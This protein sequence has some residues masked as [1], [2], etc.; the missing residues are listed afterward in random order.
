MRKLSDYILLYLKGLAM[1]ATDM[2]GISGGSVAL[3]TGL[4]PELLQTIQ[5]INKSNLK[6]LL[7]F[8]IAE[9]WKNINGNFL[10]VLLLGVICSVFYLT[11]FT[12]YFFTHYPILTLS[13]FFGLIFI[14]SMLVLKEIQWRLGTILFFLTGL[15]S[16]VIFTLVPPTHLPNNL[17]FAFGA[18][19]L[20]SCAILIPGLSGSFILLI[21]GK[22]RYIINA[23]NTFNIPI[24]VFFGLGAIA[25]FFGF[26][27]VLSWILDNYHGTTVALLAGVM[28]GSLN[29]I[30]PWREITEYVTDNKGDQVPLFDHSIV[31]WN[32]LSVTGKDPL[33]FQ[34]ILMMALA[35]FI[36]VFIERVNTRL[37]TKI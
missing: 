17:F 15:I 6:L 10:S 2:I 27:R 21:T 29:K 5:S 34:A 28:L 36:I 37:K 24:I 8:R 13:F 7:S 26:A 30:W 35:V 3:V 20:T 33:V 25:G 4:Y 12:S 18:G 31:P 11:K 19:A 14:S 9:F 1:G 16:G 32:Y 23:F 22:Y